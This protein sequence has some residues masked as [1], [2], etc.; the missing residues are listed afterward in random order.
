MDRTALEQTRRQL[1]TDRQRLARNG[2]YLDRL[3]EVM[4]KTLATMARAE[5]LEGRAH[6]VL[7]AAETRLGRHAEDIAGTW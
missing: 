6:D 3:D 4:A 1:A 2:G 5:A 7:V